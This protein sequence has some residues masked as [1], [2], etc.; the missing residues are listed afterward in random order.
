MAASGDLV[1]LGCAGEGDALGKGGQ[2]WLGR[3]GRE[4]CTFKRSYLLPRQQAAQS[5]QQ[6][7]GP[8][9]QFS[10]LAWALPDSLFPALGP[11]WHCCLEEG[12]RLQQS[13]GLPPASWEDRDASSTDVWQGTRGERGDPPPDRPGYRCFL[14]ERGFRHRRDVLGLR[15]G[16]DRATVVMVEPVC[17][18]RPAPRLCAVAEFAGTQFPCL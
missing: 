7:P 9:G 16:R 12:T 8:W 4:A 17:T 11:A 3:A 14:R 1:G 13:A 10:P 15:R 2:V 6:R 5:C 18:L